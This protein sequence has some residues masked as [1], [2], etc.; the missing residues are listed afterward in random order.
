MTS[1]DNT[2]PTQADRIRQVLNADPNGFAATDFL[3]PNVRDG[4]KPIIRAAARVYEL[5]Q[6]GLDIEETRERNGVARYR[7]KT[8]PTVTDPDGQTR[9]AA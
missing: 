4:G 2:Q 5:R 7:L 1:R 6:A 9:I 3:A 8:T